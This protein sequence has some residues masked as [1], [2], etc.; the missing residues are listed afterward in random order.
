MYAFDIDFPSKT[1]KSGNRIKGKRLV[2]PTGMASV[3]H[4]V[5]INTAIAAVVVTSGW[6][7]TKSTNRIIPKNKTK[8]SSMN[9]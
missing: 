3:T 7:G 9:L 6:L 8:P 4:Q 5:A 1:P 2:I